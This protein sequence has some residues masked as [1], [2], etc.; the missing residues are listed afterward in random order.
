MR[1]IYSAHQVDNSVLSEFRGRVSG[2]K[3]HFRFSGKGKTSQVRI[4]KVQEEDFEKQ[5]KIVD[6]DICFFENTI[7]PVDQTQQ[8]LS[9]EYQR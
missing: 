3:W 5:K 9:D 4:H 7:E 8:L 6:R 2:K 1:N